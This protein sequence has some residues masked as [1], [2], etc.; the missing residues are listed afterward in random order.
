MQRARGTN[1]NFTTT[2]TSLHTP[3][4]SESYTSVYLKSEA[5]ALWYEGSAKAH[6]VAVDEGAGVSMVV[7][8]TEVDGVTVAG[9]LASLTYW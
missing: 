3:M 9:W 8:H 5:T 7:C 6:V 4:K 2:N 1:I